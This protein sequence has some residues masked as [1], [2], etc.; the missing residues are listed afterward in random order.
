MKANYHTHTARCGHACGTDEDYVRAALKQGYD[1]LGFADH[2]PWPY[3]SG[4]RN[5]R[6]RMDAALMDGYLASVAG[7][8]EK[9]AGSIRVY[10]GFEAEY[11]PA[12]MPWLRDMLQE[13]PID[14]LILGNHFDET[15]ET[16]MYFGS[17]R[18]AAQLRR[19]V[20]LTVKGLETGLFMYLAHPDLFMRSYPAFDADCRA[21]ARDLAQA[22]RAMDI[23]MEYNIHDRYIEFATKRV[24]YPNPTFFE[25][26]REEG[27]RV[28]IGVD[29]HDPMELSD[30][31][32]WAR[33]ERELEAGGA[34]R[35]D[36][37]EAG[38]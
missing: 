12:Y 18:T 27:V 26:A 7:L 6:V 15:D 36:H 25:I 8:R 34:L 21:A 38:K 20:D 29:A 4:F 32:Q 30:G 11:F 1:V 2:I 23:P 24:S 13:K 37:I 35:I 10:A 22:C 14:Y 9:Y 16:G 33:A 19:Y 17:C 3:A 5:P 28:L 31:T